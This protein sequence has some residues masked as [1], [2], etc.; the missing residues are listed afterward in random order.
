L[1]ENHQIKSETQ[2]RDKKEP[3]EAA[4]NF[5]KSETSLKLEYELYLF[6]QRHMM[7]LKRELL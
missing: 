6:V 1:Q 4:K 3:S 2:T 5:L 7:Q